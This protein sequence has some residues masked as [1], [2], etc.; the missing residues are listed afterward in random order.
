MPFTSED[1]KKYGS[2]TKRG[3]GKKQAEIKEL[4]TKLVEHGMKNAVKKL[5][6]VDTPDKYL[7][8]ITKYMQY[9]LPKNVDVTSKGEKIE[10][11][12]SKEENDV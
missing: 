8:I 6:K 11:N 7:D 1:A 2:Q 12:I 10:I 3:P 9:V 4:V 5:N